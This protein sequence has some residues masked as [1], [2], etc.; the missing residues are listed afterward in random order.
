MPK[1][2]V[3]EVLEIISSFSPE[4]KIQLQAQLPA[5][6]TMQPGDTAATAQQ[7]RS[8]TVG[9]NFQVG[10]TGVTVD[11]SQRQTLG[12]GAIDQVADR[13]TATQALL[14]AMAHLQQQILQSSQLNQIEKATAAVPLQTAVAELQKDQP[15]KTLI[16]Q[17]V[18]ALK[19]GLEG[20]ETLADPV[21][22]VA[23]LVAKA[24]ILL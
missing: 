19:K 12:N 15:D 11:M 13:D 22:R 7:S 24:W 10:G 1:Y 14:Q 2:T 8:M 16:D 3:A 18:A 23:A 21:M 9:G 6:L 4:E 5:I 17:S 20:V